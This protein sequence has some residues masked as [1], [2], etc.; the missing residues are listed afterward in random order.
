MGIKTEFVITSRCY[1]NAEL[2][3]QSRIIDICNRERATT[4]INSTRWADVF[5]M[6]KHSAVLEWTFS[7]LSC[8]RFP[9]NKELPGLFLIFRLSTH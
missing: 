1:G 5:T 9:T 7:L 8:T 6:L 3:G 4:Y 2:I